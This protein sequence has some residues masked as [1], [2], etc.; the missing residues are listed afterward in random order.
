MIRPKEKVFN[1]ACELVV[2]E[3]NNDNCPYISERPWPKR[4]IRSI[5]RGICKICGSKL[6]RPLGMQILMH[7]KTGECPRWEHGQEYEVMGDDEDGRMVR[8]FVRAKNRAKAK[9]EVKSE[10]PNARFYK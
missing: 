1:L 6:Y 3:F 8:G 4:N 7:P 2:V 9:E 10:Y 5:R